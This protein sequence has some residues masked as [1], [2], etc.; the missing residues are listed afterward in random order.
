MSLRSITREYNQQV[1]QLGRSLLHTVFPSD[2]E[3]YMMALELTDADGNTIDYLSFPIMPESIQKTELK[4]TTIKKTSSGVTVMS[5]ATFT[6]EEITIKGNFGR[7]FKIMLGKEPSPQG[8]AFS[9]PGGKL[10]LTEKRSIKTP[11]FSIGVKNGYGATKIL[12]SI[13]NKSNG[14]GNDGRP[15]RLYFY[16]MALGESYLVAVPQSGLQLSMNQEKNMIWEY[17]LNLTTI[18]PLS[19][20]FFDNTKT[21]FSRLLSTS[22]VQSGLNKLGSN[23]A[24]T[25]RF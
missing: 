14:V 2:F 25:I 1:S 13:I 6:P 11:N 17:T 18:A 24:N 23:I 15:F 10:N 3:V 21:S 20:S 4:R 12:Q 9:I 19:L 22:L 8:V 16:N 5:S 7:S